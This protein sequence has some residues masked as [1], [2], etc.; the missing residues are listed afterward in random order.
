MQHPLSSSLFSGI[1]S[2]I[3]QTA[4]DLV[5]D[6]CLFLASEGLDVCLL[7]NDINLRNKAMMSS[8]SAVSAKNLSSKLNIFPSSR[9]LHPSTSTTPSQGGCTFEESQMR[10][11]SSTECVVNVADTRTLKSSHDHASLTVSLGQEQGSSGQKTSRVDSSLAS[12]DSILHEKITASLCHTLG[13]ILEA[14]MKE[15]YDDLWLIIIKHKPPWSLQ[16]VFACWNKHWIAVMIDRF[17]G[18]MK[19]L[20]EEVNS[21]LTSSQSDAQKLLKKVQFLYSHFEATPYS[22]YILP[23]KELSSDAVDMSEVPLASTPPPPS[24][25]AGPHGDSELS[26]VVNVEKMINQ[27][28]AHITHFVYVSA[29]CLFVLMLQFNNYP[30]CF[31][32]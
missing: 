2:C 1:I 12:K 28:G 8:L 11:V 32:C 10:D 21:F 19:E 30:D 27:V 5:R 29:G 26:G 7:T 23:V 25:L 22:K 6:Y 13:N 4:D 14:V 20:L 3:L 24:S 18:G 16:D 9:L 17:P 15:V 31:Q